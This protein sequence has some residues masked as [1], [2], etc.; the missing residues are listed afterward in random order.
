LIAS[1][2]NYSGA[3]LLIESII[4]GRP[5]A[6]F[7]LHN[8]IMCC[9]NRRNVTVLEIPSP[10]QGSPYQRGL[11]HVEFVIGDGRKG[12]SP[13]N[14]TYHQSTLQSFIDD[15]DDIKSWNV[16][17]MNKE[18][19]PDVSFRVDLGFRKCSVKFHLLSLECVV[20]YEIAHG[21]M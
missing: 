14:D 4:G 20:R 2:K 19:N 18:I 6:T 5:I 11:E 17:A 10:K 13:I 16:K 12:I 9:S 8:G 1:L 15:H 21:M 3:S 7:K